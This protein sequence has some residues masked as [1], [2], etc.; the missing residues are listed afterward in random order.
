[1]K[2]TAGLGSIDEYVRY[3]EAGA[4]EFFCGYVPYEWNRKYGTIL[5]LN[6][7]EVLGVNVQIGAESELRILAALV[8]K[9]VIFDVAIG[10]LLILKVTLPSVTY[11]FVLLL[12]TVAVNC[13]FVLYVVIL[14][15]TDILVGIVPFND[16]FVLDKSCAVFMDFC[17][18][19]FC[20]VECVT[21]FVF[22]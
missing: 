18:T 11:S 2:I 6:R 4:D 3:V 20:V 14:L 21:S 12:T 8:R 15:V 7:R 17:V 16:L 9:Y 22:A 1:M 5:P 10:E 13:T 19:S